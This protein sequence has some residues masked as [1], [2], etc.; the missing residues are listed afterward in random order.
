MK[1]EDYFMEA[2]LNSDNLI[3][4]KEFTKL[5]VMVYPDVQNR[6]DQQ[7]DPMWAG[8]FDLFDNN[9]DN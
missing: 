2:D 7:D 4:S 1:I 9:K 6:L 3:D 5:Y 8:L